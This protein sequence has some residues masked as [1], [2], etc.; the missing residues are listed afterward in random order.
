MKI[1]LSSIDKPGGSGGGGHHGGGGGG[2]HGGSGGGASTNP[3]KPMNIS[4][5]MNKTSMWKHIASE[6]SIG[7][8]DKSDNT[9][10]K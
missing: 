4:E 8:K 2:H 7:S 6:S 9:H 10:H 1:P 3:D 5:E